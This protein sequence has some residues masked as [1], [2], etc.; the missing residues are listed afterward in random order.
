MRGSVD[1]QTSMLTLRTPEQMV[2]ADH[3]IRRVKELADQT[4]ASMTGLFDQMYA[5]EGRPS[6]PPE[7]LIKSTLL[8][9]LFSVRSERLFCEQLEYNMLFRF[10]LDM[11]LDEESFDHSTFSKN[12]E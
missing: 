6:I 10:F 4:L 9:A 7:R 12:C 5:E 3:P 2:Q 1:K 8:I 11:N